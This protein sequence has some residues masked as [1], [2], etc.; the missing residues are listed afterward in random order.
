MSP[1]VSISD[2]RIFASPLAKKIANE[3]IDLS[4]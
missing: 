4:R 2:Q 1:E 3:N